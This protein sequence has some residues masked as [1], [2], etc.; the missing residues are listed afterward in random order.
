MNSDDRWWLRQCVLWALAIEAARISLLV[1]GMLALW[2]LGESVPAFAWV[3]VAFVYIGATA[4]RVVGEWRS[5]A[6]ERRVLRRI[7]SRLRE[8]DNP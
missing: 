8:F 5:G 2:W 7:A 3:V 6:Q 1:A 4:I